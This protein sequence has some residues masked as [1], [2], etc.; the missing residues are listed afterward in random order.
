MSLAHLYRGMLAVNHDAEEA[1]TPEMQERIHQY[2]TKTRDQ[3][4]LAKLAHYPWLT[5][6]VD[7]VLRDAED[8][9]VLVAWA[10]R[11]GRSAEEL[12]GRLLGDKRVSVLMPLAE[13]P[14]MG[15][16][17]Y[18]TIARVDS[19]KLAEALV[20]NTSVPL[21]VRVDKLRQVV[22]KSPRG[23]YNDHVGRIKKMCRCS[24]PDTPGQER[25]L[26]EAIAENT[27]VIPYI[28]ACLSA[29]YVRERDLDRWI[30]NLAVYYDY[31]DRTWAQ[32][33]GDLV[34]AISTQTLTPGQRLRLLDN[35]QKVL[36]ANQNGW[37]THNLKR[38]VESLGDFDEDVAKAFAELEQ[39]TT[40][41]EFTTRLAHLKNICS[42]DDRPKIGAICA[43]NTHA[44]PEAILANV[45]LMNGRE[46]MEFLTKRL[47]HRGDLVTLV[48][49]VERHRSENYPSL[50]IR[51]LSNPEPVLDLYVE[52]LTGRGETLPNW[53][54][55][56]AYIRTRPELLVSAMQW[57]RVAKLLET[58]PRLVKAVEQVLTDHLQDTPS[59]WE[60]LHTL[61]ESFDGS[62]LD[63][64]G[65][66]QALST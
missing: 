27:K 12:S 3:S 25:R 41:E 63:L 20:A 22:V 17:V 30:D 56:T 65:A 60:A 50:V 62:L 34:M 10:T 36:A 2:A 1:L 43:R 48:K 42:R 11:P 52:E 37:Y 57:S 51:Y 53:F 49:L 32:K 26:Y 24:G 44:G 6:G 15:E 23:A 46:D 61:S 40:E 4:L 55:E 21:D 54:S 38:A 28:L 45:E 13:L 31:D 18:R 7:D 29:G 5:K 58:E 16:E 8:L 64:V 47:E 14:D 59:A 33:A 19:S 9:Q 66:A 39:S 35:A